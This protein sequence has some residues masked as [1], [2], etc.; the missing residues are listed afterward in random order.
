VLVT[1]EPTSEGEARARECGA[2]YLAKDE[3]LGTRLPTILEQL[4][5]AV[6]GVR[7]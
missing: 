4:L 1:A 3:G 6:P 5:H 2:G 7:S